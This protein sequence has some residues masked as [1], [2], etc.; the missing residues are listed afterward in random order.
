ME[1]LSI[2]VPAFNEER[3]IKEVLAILVD[4]QL[5]QNIQKEIIIVNDASS[6]STKEII[7]AFITNH[8]KAEI[9]LINQ[10]ANQ[11]KG[12]ALHLGINSAT[13]DY[14]IPQDADL[15]LDPNDINKLLQKAL[16]ENLDVVYGSRFIED[17]AKKN[18]AWMANHFLSFMTNVLGKFRLSDM[19]CCYKL[20]RTSM[21]QSLDLKEK[22]FGFEPE[23]TLKLGKIPNVSF[24]EVGI[25]YEQRTYEEGKKIGW[26]DGLHA[27]QCLIKYR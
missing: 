2:I 4:L 11:G 17:T 14:L 6:D 10:E 19:E 20:V 23:I 27:L 16:D 13:G 26:K 22:R 12:A 25:S 21:A 3:T 9:R 7:D 24:G 1:K 15:E 5:I 8:P 18:L